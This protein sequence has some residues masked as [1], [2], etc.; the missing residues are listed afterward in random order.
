MKFKQY[1]Q[2]LASIDAGQ[3]E[4]AHEPAG[5]ESSSIDN[6]RLRMAVNLRL[7]NE[8]NQIF[9]SPE[10]GI[11]AIRKVLAR[12]GFSL[13]ALYDADPEGDEVIIEID[14]FGDVEG[15]D[16]YSVINWPEFNSNSNDDDNDGEEDVRY[17]VYILYYL[18]DEGHYDFYAEIGDDDRMEELVSEVGDE[19]EEE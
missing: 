9:L 2:E 10:N 13:P 18:T 3:A 4:E 1:L 11:Q 12:Y 15:D 14:Q 16:P 7:V 17:S 6:P 8:L 5:E 19:L